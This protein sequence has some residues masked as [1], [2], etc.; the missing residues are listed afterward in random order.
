MLTFYFRWHEVEVNIIYKR[1]CVKVSREKR[2][3]GKS[4]EFLK[5]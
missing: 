2:S 3:V 4:K 1:D 5:A